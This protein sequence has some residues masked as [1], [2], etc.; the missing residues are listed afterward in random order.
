MGG[1]IDEVAQDHPLRVAFNSLHGYSVGAL[2]VG[3]IAGIIALLLI[4]RRARSNS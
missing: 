4:A 1:H 3:M 2:A